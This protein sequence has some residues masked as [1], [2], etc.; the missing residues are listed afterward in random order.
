MITPSANARQVYLPAG[1]WFDFWSNRQHAG[2][3]TIHWTSNQQAQMPLFVREGSI[4]PMLLSEVE[5]LCDSN[6]VNNANVRTP[7]AG[8][9]FLIYPGQSSHFTVY[10]GTDIQC[11]AGGGKLTVTLLSV[12]RPVLL[13]LLAKEPTAVMRDGTPVPKFA[14][15]TQLEAA[16]AGWR[17][18]SQGVGF[19]VIKF[20]HTGGITKINF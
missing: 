4:V 8:M 14:T 9:Q 1:N 7:D 2:G 18:D 13:Q 11:D 16:P 12:S 17:A 19:V 5:T 10:D 15:A 3:Q 20:Q 6:Y